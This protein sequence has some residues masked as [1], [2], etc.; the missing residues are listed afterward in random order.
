ATPLALTFS[1]NSTQ[2]AL[3]RAAHSNRRLP[4]VVS[5]N[6]NCSRLRMG[7]ICCY[8]EIN[9]CAVPQGRK[10]ALAPL[11]KITLAKQT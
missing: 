7:C 3:T 5:L 6:D 10:G 2:A 11:H 1:L 8:Y 4:D 9:N